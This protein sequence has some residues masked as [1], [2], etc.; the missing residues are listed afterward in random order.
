MAG[1]ENIELEQEEEA[2]SQEIEQVFDNNFRT[3]K[4]KEQSKKPTKIHLLTHTFFLF[5]GRNFNPF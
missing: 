1:L 3:K 5:S 4:K 2:P